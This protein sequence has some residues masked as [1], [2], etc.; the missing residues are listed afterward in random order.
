MK[1]IASSRLREAQNRMEAARPFY[2]TA[3]KISEGE[4]IESKKKSLIVPICTDRGLCGALNTSVVKETKSIAKHREQE[5]DQAV[6][7]TVGDKAGALLQRDY[8]K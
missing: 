7:I 4:S 5:G 3:I 6:L 2:A 1:M 8:G